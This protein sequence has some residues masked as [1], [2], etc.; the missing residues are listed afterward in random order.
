MGVNRGLDEGRVSAWLSAHVAEAVPPFSFS[1][2]AGGR[3]NLTFEVVEGPTPALVLNIPLARAGDALR[4][5]VRAKEVRY[6]VRLDGELLAVDQ[7]DDLVDRG[8]YA[9][10][11]E[12]AAGKD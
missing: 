1:L 5:V 6:L 11:A 10:L 4:V 3:S 9:L 7:S 2:I 8:V 12:L